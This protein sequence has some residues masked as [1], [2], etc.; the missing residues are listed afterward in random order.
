MAETTIMTAWAPGPVE[1]GIILVIVLVLFGAGKLPQLGRSI[2]GA[3][4]EF[5]DSV[6]G[7][8]G[9]GDDDSKTEPTAAS[10]EESAK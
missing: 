7:G 3:I 8:G 6:K 10:T 1:L 4:T 9:D 2:G 5:R